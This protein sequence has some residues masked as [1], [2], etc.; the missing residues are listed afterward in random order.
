MYTFPLTFPVIQKLNNNELGQHYKL[1]A[2][3]T[4]IGDLLRI[5]C[6]IFLGLFIFRKKTSSFSYFLLTYAIS[7]AFI[8]F[9]AYHHGHTTRG[10]S[11]Y[12]TALVFFIFYMKY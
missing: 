12:I 1:A 3:L 8:G 11:E 7:A 9:F 5:L 6:L 10:I 2:H 4:L